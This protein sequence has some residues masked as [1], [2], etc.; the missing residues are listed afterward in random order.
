[1]KKR[2][3]A[4]LAMAGL[5]AA[6]LPGVASAGAQKFELLGPNGDAW[7]NGSGVV[8]GAPGGFGFAVI[9]APTDSGTVEATVSLKG[10]SPN[11][12]YFVFLI[13]GNADCIGITGFFTTNGKGNGTI[14]VS[15]PSVSTHAHVG[16]FSSDFMQSYVTQTYSH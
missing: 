13:Q 5:M 12:G 11:T 10:L 3:M 9:K 7:C 1:M 15:E 14:T 16:V 4:G 2:L 6:M 8:A